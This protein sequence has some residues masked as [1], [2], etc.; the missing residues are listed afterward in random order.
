M[1][2]P[3]GFQVVNGTLQFAGEQ[4]KQTDKTYVLK[5]LKNMYGLKQAGHNWYNHLTDNLLSI[6]FRQSRIDKCLF[7]CK[8]CIILIYV[9]DC[10]IFSPTETTLEEITNHLRTVFS[11]TSEIDVGAYLGID[12]SR[13]AQGQ[14][15]LRQPG[16]IDKAIAL[17]GLENELNQHNTPADTILHSVIPDDGPRQYTWSYWQLISLLNYIASTSRPDISFA[18]HQ[19][20]RF[21]NNP[22]RTHELALKRIIRYH[23][24]TRDKGYILRPN[25]TDTI[26]CYVD[27]DFAG[28]WNLETSPDP[29]SV[30][31]HSGYVITYAGC[32]ILWSS[33]L[34]SEIVLSTTEAEYIPLSTSLCDLIPMKTIPY[35]LSDTFQIPPLA[36]QTR[37]T[38]FEDNKSCVDLVAA[39][40]MCPRS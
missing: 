31:S 37:S 10:L 19:C 22:S 2:I 32:P 33:K 39:P 29:A 1:E 9:D 34:Q 30:K 5:L 6:G 23:K 26:D 4:V 14:L 7:I 38:V 8:D 36:A 24:G 20:A 15:T 3:A 27:A 17:C 11:I 21:S 40:T 35:E 25:G 12:I 18:V 28:T 16:L 13:N